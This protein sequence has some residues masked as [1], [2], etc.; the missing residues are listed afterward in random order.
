MVNLHTANLQLLNEALEVLVY[1]YC[2]LYNPVDTALANSRCFCYIVFMHIIQ[3]N[4]MQGTVRITLMSLFFINNTIIYTKAFLLVLGESGMLV[5]GC[6]VFPR[7]S[8]NLSP[9]IND[10]PSSR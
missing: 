3:V 6:K 4:N 5:D 1:H 10:H 9:I 8:N 7:T 2:I